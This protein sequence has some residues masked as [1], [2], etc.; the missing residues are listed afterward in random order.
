MLRQGNHGYG[1]IRHQ[2]RKSIIQDK[3]NKQSLIQRKKSNNMNATTN[4]VKLTGNLG[5][6]PEIRT[7]GDGN[8]LVRFSM[9]TQEEF[10]LKGEKKMVTNWHNIC[11]R[12]KVADRIEGELK[13][14]SFVSLEGRLLT[15]KY[16]DENGNKKYF[17][18][19]QVGEYTLLQKAA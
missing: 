6:D 16:D 10:F 2:Y 12:G 17:T 11:A 3:S 14:G 4:Q 7:F 9:A 19:V 13:K 5:R 15:R 18:E 1:H 8:K